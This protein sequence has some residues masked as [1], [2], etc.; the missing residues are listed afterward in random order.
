MRKDRSAVFKKLANNRVNR[1]LNQY[2]LLEN[3]HNVT[4]YSYTQEE[5]EAI[6][7]ALS[8]AH[9]KLTSLYRSKPLLKS[10][11][12]DVSTHKIKNLSEEKKKGH[13]KCP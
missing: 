2:R 7:D 12:F 11:V 9:K 10:S 13:I 8:L 6:L 1:I 5:L 3:L 4:N